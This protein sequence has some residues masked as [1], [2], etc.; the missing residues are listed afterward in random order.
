LLAKHALLG[1][2]LA[3]LQRVVSFSRGLGR[4]TCQ[5]LQPRGDSQEMRARL[6]ITERSARLHVVIDREGQLVYSNQAF[7]AMTG[8]GASQLAECVSMADLDRRFARLRDPD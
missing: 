2:A 4:G 6:A 8:W 5:P 3:P 7:L 1:R